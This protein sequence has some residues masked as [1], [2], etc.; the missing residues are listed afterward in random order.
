[1]K[2]MCVFLWAATDI[3]MST[4]I[5]LFLES[6]G[7]DGE[8][9]GELFEGRIKKKNFREFQNLTKDIIWKKAMKWSWNRKSENLWKKE[10]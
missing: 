1:M 4:P 10:A 5:F 9:S 3:M 6:S 8:F 7:T 2:N